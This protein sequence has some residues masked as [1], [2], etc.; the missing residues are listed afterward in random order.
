M[1]EQLN[2]D[3][4]YGADAL[5]VE[6]GLSKRQVYHAAAAQHIPTFKIGSAIC[7]RRSTLLKWIEDQERQRGIVLE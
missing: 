2:K 1:T 7:A 3:L 6:L 4:I 5:A